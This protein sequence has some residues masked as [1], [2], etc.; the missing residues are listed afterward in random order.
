MTVKWQRDDF[1]ITDDFSALDIT[2]IHDFLRHSYWAKEIPR[3]TVV[4]SLEHSIC[5]GMFY[6]DKQ[7]GFCRVVTDCA[8]FAYLADVFV[9][10][11]FRAQGLGKWLVDC[12]L[13]HPDLQGLRRWMLSTLDAHWLYEKHNFV[14]LKHPDWFMEIAKPNIY[15]NDKND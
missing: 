7:I 3:E 13:A 10:E 11:T 6:K 12:V 8:T 1:T 14:P 15:L 4:R 9:M 5:F 2:L